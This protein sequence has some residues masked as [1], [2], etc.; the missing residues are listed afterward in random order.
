MEQELSGVVRSEPRDAQHGQSSLLQPP[1]NHPSCHSGVGRNP[2][3]EAG[4]NP[5]DEAFLKALMT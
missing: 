1:R 2:V 5:V 4:W 3:D